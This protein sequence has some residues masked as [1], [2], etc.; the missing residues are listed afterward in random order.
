MNEVDVC[1]LDTRGNF[2]SRK[3]VRY[4]T[5]DDASDI[6]RKTVIKLKAEKTPALITVREL[7]NNSWYLVKSERV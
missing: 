4:N 3:T 1:Y 5:L 2:L 7:K 6:F